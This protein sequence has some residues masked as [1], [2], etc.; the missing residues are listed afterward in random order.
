MVYNQLQL[1]FTPA[2]AYIMLQLRRVARFRAFCRSLSLS[3]AH[4]P[5][6]ETQPYERRAILAP[7]PT[8]L[9]FPDMQI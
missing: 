6:P 4:P 1:P 5:R 3:L 9:I 8:S 7:T 2:M